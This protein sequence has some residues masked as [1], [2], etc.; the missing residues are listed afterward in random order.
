MEPQADGPIASVAEPGV[1]AE[2]QLLYAMRNEVASLLGRSQTGFPGAQP[3][4]FGR[5]H[6]EALK[7]QEYVKHTRFPTIEPTLRD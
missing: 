6:I 3:V 1:K 2:G 5:K 4:S 7:T